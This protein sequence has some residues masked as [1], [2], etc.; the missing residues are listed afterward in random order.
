M[1]P[2]LLTGAS[3]NIG[4]A[5]LDQ[6]KPSATL[7]TGHRA[8]LHG[9]IAQ[10]HFDL[11]DPSSF[12]TALER[13]HTV[14]LLRPPQLSDVPRYFTPFVQTARSAGVQ[15]IVFLSVQGADKVRSIPH[16]KIERLLM[17]C[18][19]PYTFIRPSY[20][21]DNLTTTLCAD[22]R[23]ND[24]IEL[25][26]GNAPFR[27][28]DVRDIGAGAARILQEPDG[29]TNV[30]YTFTGPDL[31][32]FPDVCQLLSEVLG[33]TIHYHSPHPVRYF[34]EERRR[35]GNGDLALVKTA[36][37]YLP[38]WQAPPAYSS[39]LEHLIGRPCG[40]LREFLERNR[41]YWSAET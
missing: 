26:A 16:A 3:G 11:E 5:I 25:P 39:D 35:S 15:H 10:R 6:L 41:T 30:A 40:G 21:M 38:R 14:F 34:F 37:H 22:I 8:P 23:D 19:V 29:H 1:K 2:T 18:G 24:R 17:Q 33:R 7:F 9:S 4:R 20:F 27:W 32:A 12:P 13:I 31:L 28:I 36:L